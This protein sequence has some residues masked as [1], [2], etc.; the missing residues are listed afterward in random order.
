[1]RNIHCLEP[2]A[3]S[4]VFANTSIS[5]DTL[6]GAYWA[7]ISG[8]LSRRMSHAILAH[9]RTT[10]QPLGLDSTARCRAGLRGDGDTP[11]DADVTSA[12]RVFSTEKSLQRARAGVRRQPVR[13]FSPEREAVIALG[14]QKPREMA[15]I[16]SALPT[17]NQPSRDHEVVSQRLPEG[18]R[19]GRSRGVRTR[20][21]E[22]KLE[23][24]HDGSGWVG[25]GR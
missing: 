25:G 7:S 8:S 6:N 22:T 9:K 21:G 11:R 16:S 5:N 19:P 17:P 1:M 12:V 14:T 13:R 24:G 18:H 10:R 4:T 15:Q 3:E 23:G 2:T 20:H